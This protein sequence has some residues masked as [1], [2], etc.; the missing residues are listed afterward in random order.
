MQTLY[1]AS[2]YLLPAAFAG[3]ALV[4]NV[5]FFRQPDSPQVPM[6]WS[7]L[8]GKPT[9]ELDSIYKKSLPHREASI[10]LWGAARYLAVGEGRK[11]VLAGDA[12][13]LFT[14]EEVRLA[15]A[16]AMAATVGRIAGI[17]DTLTGQGVQLVLVPLPAKLDVQA[18]VAGQPDL[19]NAMAAQYAGF[20]AQLQ[21]AGVAV[22]DTRGA[23]LG[24]QAFYQTDT[25]WNRAGVTAVAQA[26]AASGLVPQGDTV[27]QAQDGKAKTFTGD[28]V[29]YVT[30]DAMAPAI[31]LPP[32]AVTPMVAV[33]DAGA[34]DLFG[35]GAA[36]V[37][38]VGTSYSANADWS[39]AEVLKVVLA[40]DVLNYAEQGQGP[41]RP[42]LAYLASPDLQ[43]APPQVVIWEFPIR[44]LA[45]PTIW[46]ALADKVASN[47]N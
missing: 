45:D 28:L 6:D 39:F 33:S 17:N 2:R 26:V 12:G 8:R 13:W 43:D 23:M 27:F 5:A 38:L 22:V 44:Y 4:A 29:S 15:H 24:T 20:V 14:D 42:M 21:D 34:G 19:S 35:A 11:G 7:S 47:G 36:D 40:R 18:D 31:G 41:A 10:G 16:A 32:E 3:Y 9:A 25:H 30:S 1:H 37:V 46:D